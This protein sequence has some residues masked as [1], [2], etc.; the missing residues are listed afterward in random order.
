MGFLYGFLRLRLLYRLRIMKPDETIRFIIENHC[1]VARYGDGEFDLMLN[2]KSIGFQ[3]QSPELAAKLEGVFEKRY[4]N[5][6]ICVPGS[7][8]R[9][10]GRT[11]DSREYWLQWGISERHQETIVKRIW[12]LS[13]KK[14]RFGDSQITRPYIA[15]KNKEKSEA[16]FRSLSL[17]W[18]GRDVLI[19][20]G[21]QTRMGIGNNLLA[22]T[23][24]IRRILAPA[25]NAF[26]KYT[27]IVETVMEHASKDT[28]VLIA[29]GP[30]AT[31]LAADLSGRGVQAVDLGHI[32]LEY[33]WFLRSATSRELIDGKYIN[34][35][36]SGH[37]VND[38]KDPDYLQQIV[39]SVS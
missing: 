19:V 15:V 37:Q 24:R 10:W 16:L 36:D 4:P 12:Q 1:S 21:E 31:V 20:E 38:C 28:L 11:R 13:G 3:D 8:N 9:V 18:E 30:T 23:E 25:T 33:E 26:A 5:L 7:F 17:I 35:M 14:Y 39:A 22:N 32:D 2:E 29:L 27:E 34:E 6:L